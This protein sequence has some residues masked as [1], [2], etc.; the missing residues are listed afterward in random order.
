MEE[1]QDP[2]QDEPPHKQKIQFDDLDFSQIDLESIDRPPENPIILYQDLGR[3][4]CIDD[5]FAP[6]IGYGP[7]DRPGGGRNHGYV[8]LKGDADAARAI[9]EAQGFPEITDFLIAINSNSTL[10]ETVGC[11]K[12]YSPSEIPNAEEYIGNYYSIIFSRRDHNTFENII[13]L[14]IDLANSVYRCPDWW[15]TIE[16]GLDFAGRAAGQTY[17]MIMLKV[18]NH[19]RDR[20]EIRKWWKHSL[21]F[22]IEMINEKYRAN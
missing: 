4:I 20:D 19:G 2:V 3:T 1:S 6:A 18:I 10:L 9:P 17:W 11:E 8:N 21:N 14:A 15:G 5:N 7:I 16:I 12:Q 22:I 13:R